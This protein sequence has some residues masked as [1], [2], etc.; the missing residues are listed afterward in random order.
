MQNIASDIGL[1]KNTVYSMPWQHV[2]PTQNG[3]IGLSQGFQSSLNTPWK[4]IFKCGELNSIHYDF[5]TIRYVV[6]FSNISIK[7]ALLA[8]PW[9]RLVPFKNQNLITFFLQILHPS[10]ERHSEILICDA[11]EMEWKRAEA[12]GFY[13]KYRYILTHI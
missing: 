1:I 9:I 2:N 3:V 12:S 7:L 8:T 5:A 11:P 13:T 10:R 4:Y 6:I